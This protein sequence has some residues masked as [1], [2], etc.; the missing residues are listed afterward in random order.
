MDP[1]LGEIRIFAGSY[2]PVDWV[3]CSGQLL[4]ISE[5]QALF[6]LLSTTWGGDGRTNFG[7]PDLRGRLPIGQG[8]GA[9]LTPRTIAQTG[10][11]SSVQLTTANCPVHSHQ[12]MASNQA[13]D[14][15]KVSSG[16]GLA[17]TAKSTTNVTTRYADSTQAAPNAPVQVN[18]DEQSITASY[19]G[20]QAHSNLM[21]YQALNYIIC[22][23]GLFP[24][25]P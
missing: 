11:A 10:G 16:V 17:T 4:S 7:L 20:S 22:I 2:A 21:P 14:T 19:G 3:F 18:L 9:N 13:S 24:D 12:L 1:Y 8:A 25:R 6:A 23:R 15:A 5:N